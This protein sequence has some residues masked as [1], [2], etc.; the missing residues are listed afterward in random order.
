MA[1]IPGRIKTSTWDWAS[2]ACG[3]SDF[4]PAAQDKVAVYLIT[5]RGV[6]IKWIRVVIE[7]N[8]SHVTIPIQPASVAFVAGPEPRLRNRL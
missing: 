2:R 6:E 1:A 8:E 3:A 4:S 5:R 7:R